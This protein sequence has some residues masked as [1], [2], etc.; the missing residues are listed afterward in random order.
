MRFLSSLLT[1]AAMLAQGAGC[2]GGQRVRVAVLGFVA[3]TQTEDDALE[4]DGPDDEIFTV[5]TVTTSANG[6]TP[7]VVPY[8]SATFGCARDRPGRIAVGSNDRGVASHSEFPPKPWAQVPADKYP[9]LPMV[10]FDGQ[11]SGDTNVTIAPTIWEWDGTGSAP[12][13]FIEGVGAQAS[14]DPVDIA[15]TKIR[16]DLKGLLGHAEDRPIGIHDGAFTPKTITINSKS[17]KSLLDAKFAGHA[18]V[19]V[20]E[21]RDDAEIGGGT[22][23]IFLS[24]TAVE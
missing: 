8:R 17:L 3:D 14:K 1:I 9:S 15:G 23:R 19:H 10:I 24:V 5:T 7:Q 2:D 22:Y 12:S 16:F 21:Y 11:I 20:I 13:R 6:E 4:R 18:G